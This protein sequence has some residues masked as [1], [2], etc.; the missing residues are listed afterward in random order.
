MNFIFFNHIQI[1]SKFF[2]HK[3]FQLEKILIKLLALA[4]YQEIS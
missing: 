1:C 3:S 2:S 4:H